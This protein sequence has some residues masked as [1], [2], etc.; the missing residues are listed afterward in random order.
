MIITFLLVYYIV[1]RA[2]V[3]EQEADICSGVPGRGY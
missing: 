3:Y 1:S 2:Y